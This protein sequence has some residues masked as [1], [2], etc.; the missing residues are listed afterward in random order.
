[1]RRFKLLVTALDVFAE[2]PKIAPF[3]D[4]IRQ[5][6]GRWLGLELTEVSLKA[7]TMEGL[8]PIGE[9]K[10]IAAQALVSLREIKH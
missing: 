2:E 6:L 10:G 4:A 5:N 8:G 7:K 1:M 3:S 9:K